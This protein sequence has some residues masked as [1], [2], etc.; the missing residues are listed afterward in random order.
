MLIT[1]TCKCYASFIHLTPGFLLN[2]NGLFSHKFGL[3]GAWYLFAFQWLKV[4]ISSKKKM[5]T[6]FPLARSRSPRWAPTRIMFYLSPQVLS[7]YVCAFRNQLVLGMLW[8]S[9]LW[10]P[11]I[12][13]GKIRKKRSPPE[14]ESV[15]C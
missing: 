12:C 11:L 8:R 14:S 2:E 13:P 15:K 7:F 6:F 4:P 5:Y 9:K 1:V 10:S 3:F